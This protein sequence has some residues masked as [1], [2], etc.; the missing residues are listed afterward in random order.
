[1]KT[2]IER[3]KPIPAAWGFRSIKLGWNVWLRSG[4]CVMLGCRSRARARFWAK[5]VRE[6][7]LPT[8]HPLSPA[9]RLVGK[10]G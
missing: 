10:T 9:Y 8:W 7:T 2:L 3:G 1:M 5:A 4:E 6:N